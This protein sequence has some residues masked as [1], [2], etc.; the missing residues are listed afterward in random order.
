MKFL[1]VEDLENLALK[2][3]PKP[4]FRGSYINGYRAAEDHLWKTQIEIMEDMLVGHR[5]RE[6]RYKEAIAYLL[7]NN[8]DGVQEYAVK[9]FLQTGIWP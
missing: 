1:S 4:N 9:K 8:E 3:A 5:Q 2:E 7:R 6:E